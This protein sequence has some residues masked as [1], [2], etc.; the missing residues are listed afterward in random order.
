MKKL[1][2]LVIVL[3]LISGCKKDKTPSPDETVVASGVNVIP[4]QTWNSSFVSIDTTHY[5]II[6]SDNSA[7]VK[8]GDIIVSSEG[9]GLLRKV[10]L[11]TNTSDGKVEVRTETSYLTDLIKQGVIEFEQ[12]LTVS[13]IDKVDYNYS[14]IKLNTV[15]TK[16]ADQMQFNWDINTVLFDLDKNLT[17]TADQI[18]IE[19]NLNCDWKVAARIDIGWFAGLKEVKFGFESSQNLNLDL[20]A[21]LQYSSEKKF[22]L[23]TINFSPITVMAG[24]VP[25]VFTPQ[26]KVVAGI[27]GYANA[28]VTTGIE[29]AMSFNAGLQYLRDKGWAPFQEFNKNLTFNPPV[30][31][32]NA[33]AEVY[34]KPEFS[35]KI[36]GVAGP[37]ASLKLYSRIEADLLQTPWWK[38]YGGLNMNAGVK[39]DILDK[40]LLE[41]NVSDLLDYETV[42]SE[43]SAPPLTAPAVTT[44]TIA[45][46]TAT[47]ADGGGNVTADGGATV[48][49][50]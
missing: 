20:I 47:T 12:P 37:Y 28:S 36:Y 34:V 40:F 3:F 46:V 30:L 4:E 17:T 48:T 49:V 2:Y 43:A 16:G 23:A 32:M 6:L 9:E 42:L 33:G 15:D 39:V 38:L 27:N 11:V 13:M 45:N 21:G 26:M 7:K 24:A 41:Y 22:T 50:K 35:V 5:T 18:R 44:A 25:V 14:G 19:G 29:Q 31:N 10:S 8:A 1:L